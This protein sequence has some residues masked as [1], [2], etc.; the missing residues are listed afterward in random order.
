M[1]VSFIQTLVMS[2][3]IR[4]IYQM[5]L[6]ISLPFSA[7]TLLVGQQEGHPA[8]KKLGF[9]WFINGDDLT[10]SFARL[11]APSVTTTSI[12][13]APIISSMETFWYQLMLV[14]LEN[15]R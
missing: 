7:S 11:M 13:L 10:W 1:L 2:L 3:S 8:C 14:H 4:D 15:G 9:G 5:M 12:S 6:D